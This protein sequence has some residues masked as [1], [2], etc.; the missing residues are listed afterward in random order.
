LRLSFSISYREKDNR[1]LPLC[2]GVVSVLTEPF[3]T[4]AFSDGIKFLSS[5]Y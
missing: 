4:S 5:T 2:Q 3:R 1:N